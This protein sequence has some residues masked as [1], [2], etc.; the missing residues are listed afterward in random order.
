ME[1]RFFTG[2]SALIPSVSWIWYRYLRRRQHRTHFRG[3]YSFAFQ[4]PLFRIGGRTGGAVKIDLTGFDQEDISQS[5]S[6]LYGALVQEYGNTAV[7]PDPANFNVPAPELQIMPDL[8]RLTDLNLTVEDLGLTVQANGDG[9]L[10]RKDYHLGGDI[11]DL[12]LISGTPSARIT[13]TNLGDAKM[14][15]P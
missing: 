13:I 9:V 12:K 10:F 11:I 7:R 8:D 15:A 4:S 1:R 14:A 5:A 3:V 2:V 6:A